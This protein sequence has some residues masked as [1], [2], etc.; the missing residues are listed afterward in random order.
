MFA[1]AAVE[2]H[3]SLVMGDG[4]ELPTACAAGV[5]L[6]LPIPSAAANVANDMDAQQ[7]QWDGQNSQYHSKN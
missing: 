7:Y 1:L 4:P 6:L 5:T 3:A 2:V